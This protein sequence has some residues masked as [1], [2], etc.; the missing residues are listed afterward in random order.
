MNSYLRSICQ[1]LLHTLQEFRGEVN[2]LQEAENG[3]IQG[4]SS[5]FHLDVEI[6][7]RLLNMCGILLLMVVSLP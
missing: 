6:L 2:T 5:L 4:V 3:E 1:N 7:Q